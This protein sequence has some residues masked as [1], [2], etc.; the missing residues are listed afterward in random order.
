MRKAFGRSSS[1]SEPDP[2]GTH[3]PLTTIE[4]RASRKSKKSKKDKV[5]DDWPENVYKPGEPM[6]R[7]KYRGPVNFQ[8]QQKLLSFSFGDAFGARRKSGTSQ[9]SPM[10]S[11]LPSRR[12]SRSS[13]SVGRSSFQNLRF[14]SSRRGSRAP[15]EGLEMVIGAEDDDD[16][17]NGKSTFE[18]SHLREVSTNLNNSRSIKAAYPRKC[19]S[20]KAS[21][22]RKR[23]GKR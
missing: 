18:H 8:H 9:Y 6:P 10:G 11:R 21:N 7:P 2:N 20:S 22:D 19:P 17:T 3:D 1:V 14:S 12:G 15:P 4:S 13:V 16:V 23:S 5:P